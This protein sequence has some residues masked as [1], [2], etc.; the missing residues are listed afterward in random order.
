MMISVLKMLVP[1]LS[2]PGVGLLYW[3]LNMNR[4]LF[5]G[6]LGCGCCEGFNTNHLTYIFCFTVM[7][8]AGTGAWFASRRVRK[9]WRMGYLAGIAVLL[10]EFLIHF[11]DRNLWL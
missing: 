11:V 1:V 9:E 7:G 4:R 10:W 3:D 6:R 8:A 2:L 5:V